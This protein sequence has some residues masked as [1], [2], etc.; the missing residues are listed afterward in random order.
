MREL[1]AREYIVGYLKT[2]MN[3]NI[4]VKYDHDHVIFF[5]KI[6]DIDIPFKLLNNVIGTSENLDALAVWIEK[7]L[8][9]KLKSLDKFE[10]KEDSY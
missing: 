9:E 3:E 4:Q 7:S 8:L 1:S 10:D 2:K 5:V 6:R